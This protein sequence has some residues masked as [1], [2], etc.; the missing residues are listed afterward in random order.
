MSKKSKVNWSDINGASPKPKCLHLEKDE[1][2]SLYHCPIQEC[3]HDGFQRQREAAE[4]MLTPSTVGSFTSTKTQFERNHRFAKGRSNFSIEGTT[5]DQTSK[6]TKHAVKLLPSFSLSCDI[7]EVFTKWLTGSGGGYKKDRAAQQIVTRCFKFLRFCCEDEEEL[8]FDVEDFGLCSPNLFKFID[9]LQDECKLAHGGHLGY[10]DAISE[11]I[12]FGKLHG[13]SEAVFQKFSATEL[14]LK[15]AQKT[16]AKMMRLQWTQH[17][18]IETLEARGHWATMEELLKVVKFHLPRYENTVKICK[19]SSAQVN[20]SDLT[21]AT[22]FVAMYLF[23]KEKGSS[24]MTYQYLTV[25]MIASAKEKGGFIDQK[26]FKTA[27]KYGFVTWKA[28]T[29]TNGFP[30]NG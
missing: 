28:K 17:L 4:N 2:D 25:D 22:K 12:N 5:Q 15:R 1:S 8:T 19:L 20:P 9:Y 21:F 13:T 23:I 24:P 11:M 27:G 10:I 26:V 29:D 16:V 30:L 18:D 14:Y 7:G 6:T 3:G